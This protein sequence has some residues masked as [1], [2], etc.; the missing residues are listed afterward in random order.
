M[1][2]SISFSRSMIWAQIGT[3]ILYV[4]Y[5]PQLCDKNPDSQTL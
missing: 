2:Y 5:T 1:N 3:E 4:Q